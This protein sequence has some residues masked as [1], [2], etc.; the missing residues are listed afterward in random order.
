MR[1]PLDE[2]LDR[3]TKWLARENDRPLVGFYVGSYFPFRRYAH[4][5]GRLP[6]GF[7]RPDDVVAEDYLEDTERLFEMHEEAGGDMIFSA[8]P[9][10]GMPWLEA[11]LGCTVVADHDQG[12][13]RAVAPPDFAAKPC[14]PEFSESNAWVAKLLEFIPALERQS[15]GRYPVGVTL[16]RGISDL[17]S[18]LYGGQEFIYRMID[19]P[20]EV[21]GVI[22]RLTEFW[23]AFG[24]TLLGRLPLF[25]GGTGSFFYGIWCP[26]KAIWLQEDAAALLS[27]ELYEEFIYPAD[28][29]V[30]RAFEHTVIHL[31]PSRFIPT[32][33]L[34]ASPISAVE[35]HIDYGGPRAEDLLPHYETILGAKPLLVWGDVTDR[36]LEFLLTR[37][38][39]RGLAIEPVAS[40]AEEARG[41][42]ERAAARW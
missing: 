31:H 36:D 33:Q 11:A 10:L 27:P 17:L 7:V 5:V 1:I 38:P 8:A 28:C 25:H 2:R 14:V 39:H 9:F 6:E 21:R 30:A 29:A 41:I 3:L 35:L 16:M 12:C 42:W 37:L 13:T 24:R 18:A 34:A 22:E 40:S 20:E 19:A 26:G 32:R 4:S 23:I 15:A